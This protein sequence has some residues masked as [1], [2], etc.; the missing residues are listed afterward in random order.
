MYIRSVLDWYSTDTQELLEL[1]EIMAEESVQGVNYLTNLYVRAFY[2]YHLLS[3]ILQR[4]EYLQDYA[5]KFEHSS[6]VAQSN[7]Q[8][9][10]D[11]LKDSGKRFVL[12]EPQR[13]LDFDLRKAAELD[14]TIR[15]CLR[16]LERQA[17]KD[18]NEDLLQTLGSKLTRKSGPVPQIVKFSNEETTFEYKEDE[19]TEVILIDAKNDKGE[20]DAAALQS[21]PQSVDATTKIGTA[22]DVEYKDDG[23]GDNGG[24]DGITFKFQD[25]P[26]EVPLPQSDEDR[27]N[28]EESDNDGNNIDYDNTPTGQDTAIGDIKLD[29]N[30][31]PSD[32]HSEKMDNEND[33]MDN[34]NDQTDNENDQM[35]SGFLNDYHQVSSEEELEGDVSAEQE[36][37]VVEEEMEVVPPT[38]V[39]PLAGEYHPT[40]TINFDQLELAMNLQLMWETAPKKILV[41]RK[42]MAPAL[43][44]PFANLIIW[45]DKQYS[46]ITIYAEPM[47]L[48][49]SPFKLKKKAAK[50]IQICKFLTKENATTENIDLAISLG[51]DGTLLHT[52][53]LFPYKMPPIAAFRTGTLNFMVPFKFQRNSYKRIIEN[54]IRGSARVNLRSRVSIMMGKCDGQKPLEVLHT[55]LNEIAVTRG[56]S[57]SLCKVN[58][59][60]NDQKLAKVEGDGL[61]ICTP[62]GSTAYG[63]AAG[64]SLLHP[65]VSCLQ[66]VP[67]APHTICTRPIVVPA[68]AKIVFRLDESSRHDAIVASDGTE[69]FVMKKNDELIIKS[70]EFPVPIICGVTKDTSVESTWLQSFHWGKKIDPPGPEEEDDEECQMCSF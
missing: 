47:A 48:E 9:M 21:S 53:A 55:A 26:D 44:D 52:A 6:K 22:E 8:I 50:V 41:V 23:S 63:L 5:R 18:D 40:M 2:A 17:I 57:P 42:L 46:N 56:V 15:Y 12:M 49:E 36:D 10:V 27:D 68:S 51:G 11:Y 7:A 24:E 38:V 28:N 70:S 69:S 37:D 59:F 34:E 65:S 25:Q 4:D 31:K 3:E 16:Q 64:G 43:D 1:M 61:L 45:L 29:E 14:R 67:I 60:M 66:L 39:S 33:Q 19:N 54:I 32:D 35:D 62:T 58:V 20:P 13:M 30:G